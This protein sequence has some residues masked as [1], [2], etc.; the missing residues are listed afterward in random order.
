MARR[1]QTR[2]RDT[3]TGH[4]V[5]RSTWK[6]SSAQGGHRYTRENYIPTRRRKRAQKGAPPPQVG[7]PTYEWLVTFTYE[8]TGKSID[9][10]CTAKTEDEAINVALAF[11]RRVNR[12]LYQIIIEYAWKITAARGPISPPREPQFRSESKK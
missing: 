2:Y 4:F 7:A 9:V 5:S 6:R 11:I 8:A 12:K 1:R 10:I 3:R